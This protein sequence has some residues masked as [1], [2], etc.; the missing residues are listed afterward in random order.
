MLL[1]RNKEKEIANSPDSFVDQGG[2]GPG[3]QGQA[4]LGH[5]LCAQGFGDTEPSRVLWERTEKQC[6]CRA[7]VLPARSS[8]VEEGAGRRGECY[9]RAEFL[10]VMAQLASRETRKWGQGTHVC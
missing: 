8:W 5:Q 2:W 4:L 6:A 1:S 10:A 3:G 9:C 7:G